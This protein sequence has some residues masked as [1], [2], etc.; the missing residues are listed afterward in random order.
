M[1]Y[2][3]WSKEEIIWLRKIYP[4]EGAIGFKRKYNRSYKSIYAKAYLMGLKYSGLKIIFPKKLLK[5]LY[6]IDKLSV[7]QIGKK[8]K[9]SRSNVY[10]LLIE[11]NVPLRKWVKEIPKQFNPNSYAYHYLLGAIIG[12]GHIGRNC[13]NFS[14]IDKDFVG[15]FTK[16]AKQLGFDPHKYNYGKFYFVIIYNKKF[17]DFIRKRKIKITKGFIDGFFD[18]EGCVYFRGKHKT[19]TITNN[20]KQV[21]SL[22][23][24]YLNSLKIQSLYYPLRLN[25]PTLIIVR[26]NSLLE[27]NEH[28]KFS[29]KRKQNKLSDIINSLNISH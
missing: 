9:T 10:R 28:F 2:N 8:L 13:I 25:I 4:K 12:D 27:F 24:K 23:K 6:I 21:L 3:F 1:R 17:C 11:H 15:K 19:I 5:K 29:I 14:V 20:N 22:I 16:M 7:R 26:R 18:A